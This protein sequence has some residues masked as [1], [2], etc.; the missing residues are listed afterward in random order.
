[1]QLTQEEEREALDLLRD[2]KYGKEMKTSIHDLFLSHNYRLSL[3]IQALWEDGYY[4]K[5][6]S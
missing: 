4:R 1:M 2:T 3:I 6:G 5:A